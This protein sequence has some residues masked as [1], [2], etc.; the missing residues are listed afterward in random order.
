[1]YDEP[2]A[3][4]SQIPTFLISEMAR[5]HVTVSLSGDGA[6]ELFG[7][8]NRYV[9][10][11]TIWRKLG[12]LPR[13]MRMGM[14][15]IL[16]SVSPLVWDAL[17]DKFDILL[18]SSWRYKTP[19]DKLHKLAEMLSVAS[20]DGIYERLVSQWH[21]PEQVV[22]GCGLPVM[23]REGHGATTGLQHL[24]HR[25]M[26]L[27][28]MAY[29]PD[30]ILVK[31]DRAAM[32]VSLETRAPYLDHRVAEFAWTLPLHM[33]IRNGEG[34]YLLR[35]VLDR[36]VPR[37]LIDR[38]KTGFGVPV[39]SWLRGPLKEW[40]EEMLNPNK[41]KQQGFFN[42]NPIRQKWNEHLSEKRN[43]SSQ[44]WNILMFQAWLESTE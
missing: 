11:S 15:H 32:H 35:R 26:Y 1:M 39:G 33:K 36:H 41:I 44:L 22:I 4:V 7:G 31:V 20:P 42:P 24:E 8:Y 10:A 21:N 30:D 18:P 34:K 29:L 14:A 19:G 2:F 16:T 43:W 38:L 23:T 5:Q 27:D 3:D 9:R 25:M 28:A 12:W 17:F 40:T 13:G 6:D 37:R